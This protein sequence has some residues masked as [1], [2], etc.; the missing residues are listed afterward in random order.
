MDLTD[1][2]QEDTADQTTSQG[3]DDEQEQADQ[4]ADTEEDLEG[5]GGEE[6]KEDDQAEDTT[7]GT[8]AGD[9]MQVKLPDGTVATVEELKKR[10][11]RCNRTIP[12]KFRLW[13]KIGRPPRMPALRQ[14]SGADISSSRLLGLNRRLTMSRAL[15]PDP[16]LQ[17]QDPMAYME[18]MQA[19]WRTASGDTR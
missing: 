1:D 10:T 15:I 12:G 11:S 5:D 6:I 13:R 19:L 9:D 2:P 14:P 8:Y 3:E 16:S 17:L 7:E 18:G 4:E